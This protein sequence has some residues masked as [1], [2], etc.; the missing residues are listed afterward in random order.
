VADSIDTA[1]DYSV[2]WVTIDMADLD[3]II[4]AKTGLKKDSNLL[5]VLASGAKALTPLSIIDS[6]GESITKRAMFVT[7]IP[8]EE[9]YK[10]CDQIY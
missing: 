9:V 6:V 5:K 4:A 1:K 7:L 8:S 3:N 2:T 10:F